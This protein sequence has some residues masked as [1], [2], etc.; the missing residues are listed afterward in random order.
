VVSDDSIHRDQTHDLIP[1]LVEKFTLERFSEVV[2]DHFF[3][4]AVLDRN[5]FAGDTIGNKEVPDVNVPGT[6]T[7]GCFTIFRQ[8]DGALV[9]LVK[10]CT[11]TVA[12]CL[13]EVLGP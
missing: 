10:D 7:T 5:L 9:V 6:F 2:R 13:H 8:L 3:G 1:E 12:L 11:D 4:R